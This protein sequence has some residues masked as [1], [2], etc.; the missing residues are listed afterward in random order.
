MLWKKF[1]MFI[2]YREVLVLD[3]LV[4]DLGAEQ[5]D[6]TLCS[7]VVQAQMPT[8]CV[9]LLHVYPFEQARPSPTSRLDLPYTV[10]SASIAIASSAAFFLY[11]NQFPVNRR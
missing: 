11:K 10:K 9:P 5:L 1:S 7:Q 8:R 4:R 3:G 6:C 2:L